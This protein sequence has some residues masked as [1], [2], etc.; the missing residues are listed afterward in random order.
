MSLTGPLARDAP[1]LLILHLGNCFSFSSSA[2]ELLF[3]PGFLFSGVLLGTNV[4]RVDY[5]IKGGWDTKCF[6]TFNSRE[7]FQF[8]CL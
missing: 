2:L 5:G 6:C 7:S 8:D 3:F 4:R 1:L